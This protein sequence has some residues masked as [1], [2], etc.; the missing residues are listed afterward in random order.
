MSTPTDQ[1]PPQPQPASDPPEPAHETSQRADHAPPADH[2]KPPPGDAPP[3]NL[4][5][6]TDRALQF[7]STA[8]NETLGA[9]LVGLGATTYLVLGRV[10][11]VLIGV[12]GGIVLHAQWEGSLHGFA[13][14]QTRAAEER[15][16]KE[17]GLDVLKRVMDVR[18]QTKDSHSL[19]RR[20]SELDIQLFSGKQ[21]D[22]SSFQPETGAALSELTDAIVRDYVKW[23]YN[24][25][26]PTD[27]AFP[28]A[29]RQTLTALILSVS[30]H[31]S[32]KRPADF[33]LEYLTNSSAIM[34]VFLNEL[35]DAIGGSPASSAVE[36][37]QTYLRLKP[38]SKLSNVLDKKHQE[39]KFDA[40]AEDILENYLEP[41]TYNCRPAR[42]FL[43]QIL[44]KVVLEMALT[45]MSKPEWINGWIVYMLEEGEPELMKEIDAGVEGAKERKLEEIKDKVEVAETAAKM[46]Q[47]EEKKNK[48]THRRVVSK[49]QEAMDEAMQEAQRLTQMIQEEEA[50]KAR[51]NDGN[52]KTETPKLERKKS[53]SGLSDDHSEGTTQE[54]FTPTSS[55][56]D[57]NEERP[58]SLHDSVIGRNSMND[59][60]KVR[61]STSEPVRKASSDEEKSPSSSPDPKQPFTSF[62]QI[63]TSPTPTALGG[64]PQSIGKPP[65]LTLH[66]ASISIFDDALP[67]DKSVVKSKPAGDYF[68]QIEPASSAHP[69]WMISRKYADFETLHE[70]LRRISVI[71][72]V[73]FSEAH[74]NLPS[75]GYHLL[76]V[77]V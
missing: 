27:M 76:R 13:D 65:P 6:L 73:G 33:F 48:A 31:L 60:T 64:R 46:E 26:V 9:C 34:I 12:V 18:A 44:A 36:A 41:K 29:C 24:P 17:I 20:D 45:T 53:T 35:S 62:D 23:W 4:Q 28:T 37:V 58:Q 30:S 19:R 25:I 52:E 1:P 66:N 40:V 71:S 74:P 47:A 15:R 70:V 5:A 8:T 38:E 21:L 56:S 7:L 42:I 50:A 16:R 61:P 77:R 49:A 2:A 55:Q 54:A 22:Y 32:R 43:R 39:K 10:G 11:L 57:Q 72:G 75:D 67:G 14:E 63:V 51:G 68:V 69:G 3:V 59:P